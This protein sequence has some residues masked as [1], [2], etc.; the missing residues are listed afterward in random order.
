MLGTVRLLGQAF[1]PFGGKGVEGVVH[2]ADGAPDPGSDP[3]GSLPVG[4]G[5]QDLGSPQG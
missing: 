2:G 5:R 1:D 4:A 3:G